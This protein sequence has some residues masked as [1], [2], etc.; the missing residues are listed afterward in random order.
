[1][2]EDVGYPLTFCCEYLYMNASKNTFNGV[3]HC[4]YCYLVYGWP[5]LERMRILE[6]SERIL[7]FISFAN[8]FFV[9]Q[10]KDTYTD[11][12]VFETSRSLPWVVKVILSSKSGQKNGMYKG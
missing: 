4:T 6:I 2:E 11:I 3:F 5:N 7:F 8:F 9:N 12:N 10:S 1:M